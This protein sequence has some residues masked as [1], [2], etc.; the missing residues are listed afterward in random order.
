MNETM[1]PYYVPELSYFS[2]GILSS[3]Q[4][5][6]SPIM[7]CFYIQPMCVVLH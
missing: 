4:M 3:C 5:V 6:T 2:V 1:F 7:Q